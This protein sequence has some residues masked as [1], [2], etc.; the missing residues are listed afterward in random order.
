MSLIRFSYL[1][2]LYRDRCSLPT[3]KKEFSTRCLFL[4]GACIAES[5]CRKRS[6]SSNLFKNIAKQKP[7]ALYHGAR[8]Q[9]GE[10][11][12]KM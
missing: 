9:A 4:P 10:E 3:V 11:T 7:A 5:Q 1:E 6:H 12:E 8:Q 2:A